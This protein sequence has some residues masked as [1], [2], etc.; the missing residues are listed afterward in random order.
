LSDASSFSE[1]IMPAAKPKRA[2]F[3]GLSDLAS[4][5]DDLSRSVAALRTA[6]SGLG[7][8]D[9][10]DEKLRSAQHD[11]EAVMRSTREATEAIL[12]T[13]ESLIGS[14]KSGADYRELVEA[15]MIA[16]IEACIFQDLTGQRLSRA[17]QTLKAMEERLHMFASAVSPGEGAALIGQEESQRRDWNARNLVGGPG[18]AVDQAAADGL[19]R[20]VG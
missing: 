15:R 11:L 8:T 1:T 16:L 5:A 17:A 19:M 9:M 6:I 20:A 3:A 18:G 7:V 2:S 13:A 4:D 14:T 10:T 12:E